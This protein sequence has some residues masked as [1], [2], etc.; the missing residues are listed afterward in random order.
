MA[1]K[2]GQMIGFALGLFTRGLIVGAGQA[3]SIV[4][5]LRFMGVW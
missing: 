5:V 1:S 4:V 2:A 3:V